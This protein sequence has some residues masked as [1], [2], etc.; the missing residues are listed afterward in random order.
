MISLGKIPV[1]LQ[2]GSQ[3]CKDDLHVY[4]GVL[5]AL[6]LWKTAG[7]LAILPANYPRLIETCDTETTPQVKVKRTG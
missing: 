6:I 7:K 3:S 5:G 4:P 2:L 1:T